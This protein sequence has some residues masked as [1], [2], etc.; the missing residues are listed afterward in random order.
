MPFERFTKTRSRGLIPKVSIWS[1]GQIGFNKSAVAKFEIDK[2][3]YLVL[4]YDKD[5]KRIGIKLTNDQEEG[6]IKIIRKLASGGALVSAK[7][8]LFHYDIGGPETRNYGLEL[9]ADSGLIV[10]DTERYRKSLRKIK[11]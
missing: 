5:S 9:D 6:A 8:F 10:I 4:F 11:T 1:R 7:S 2:F 3:D